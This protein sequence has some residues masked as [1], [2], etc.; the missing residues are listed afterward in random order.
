MHL[1]LPAKQEVFFALRGSSTLTTNSD[2][3]LIALIC[4]R[5]ADLLICSDQRA[6]C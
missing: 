4:A 1:H 6:I 3:I 2:N 5:F